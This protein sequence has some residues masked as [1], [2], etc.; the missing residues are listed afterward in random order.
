MKKTFTLIKFTSFKFLFIKFEKDMPSRTSITAHKIFPVGKSFSPC[1]H[2]SGLGRHTSAVV[3]PEARLTLR[4]VSRDP[5][6]MNS[7]M[8]ITGLPTQAEDKTVSYKK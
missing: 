8:I 7:V 3:P 6:S 1:S 5:F 2:G 4:K